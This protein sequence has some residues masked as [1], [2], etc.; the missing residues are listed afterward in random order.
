MHSILSLV[1][2]LDMALGLFYTSSCGFLWN[3]SLYYKYHASFSV[4]ENDCGPKTQ[5]NTGCSKVMAPQGEEPFLF[6]LLKIMYVCMAESGF[7]GFFF[8]FYKP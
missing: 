4:Y 8:A 1:K 3:L 7:N 6:K 5:K 2:Y